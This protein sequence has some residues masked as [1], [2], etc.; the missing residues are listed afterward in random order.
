MVKQAVDDQ[1]Q[2]I[3]YYSKRY[4]YLPLLELSEVFQ[5]FLQ[6]DPFTDLTS[7]CRFNNEV[8]IHVSFQISLSSADHLAQ[9]KP[10]HKCP[11]QNL[12]YQIDRILGIFNGD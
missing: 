5:V 12:K 2:I 3:S 7:I 10:L 9:A 1:I 6:E 4:I 11:P 8:K